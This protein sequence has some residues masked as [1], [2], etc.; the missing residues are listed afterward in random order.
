MKAAMK[1]IDA[2][3]FNNTQNNIDAERENYR[4]LSAS[5]SATTFVFPPSE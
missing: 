2:A 1:E 3:M 5:V 4:R